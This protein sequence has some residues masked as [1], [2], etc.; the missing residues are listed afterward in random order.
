MCQDNC[1]RKKRDGSMVSSLCSWLTHTSGPISLWL[2]MGGGGSLVAKLCLTLC[3]PTDCS[4]LGSSVHGISHVRILEWVAISFFRGIFPTQVSNPH[5]QQCRWSPALQADS[6][7]LS[8]QGNPSC[9]FCPREHME[10]EMA[11]HSSI[12][13]GRILGTEEPSGL[14]SMGSH[15]VGHDWSGLAAAAFHARH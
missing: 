5:I 9:C 6:L 2:S 11:T 14:P 4:P 8:H 7:P 15:R 1:K 12:L 10:K 13:A 3:G